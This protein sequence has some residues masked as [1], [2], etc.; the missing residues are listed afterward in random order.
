[1][2]IKL[3]PATPP[4]HVA[5]AAAR[6][7]YFPDGIVTPE[8]TAN[9]P[10]KDDLL[11]SVFNAGHHTT[12]QHTHVTLLIEG[13]S[14]HLIWR[15]LH[16]HSF[17]NSEQ[18]SQR[19]AR[20]RRENVYIPETGDKAPWE[21]FYQ[22][23]FGEYEIL[24]AL[25]VPK[26]EALLP[27][28]LKKQAVKKAQEFARYI[29]PVG[30][31]AYLYHTVN[32]I[33]LLRYI[34]AAPA[35]PEAATEG[36]LF[37]SLLEKALLELDPSLAPL[38]EEAKASP[39]SFPKI[40]IDTITSAHQIKPGEDVRIFDVV[41]GLETGTP[42]NYASVLRPSQL[43]FDTSI[44]GGFSSYLK[45]SLSADAQNQRHRRSP[46]IRPA[47]ESI[48][49]PAFYTPAL[50]EGEALQRYETIIA[51]SYRF[52]ETQR[53]KIGFGEAVYALPNAH[54]IQIV[55]RNDFA[56]FHHKAQMRLCYNAQEEIFHLTY[57][58]VEQ[59]RQ[60]Q[61][62]GSEQLLPPCTLRQ[63]QGIYPICPEGPRFC[64]IKVWKL[65][66][67]QYRRII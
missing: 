58:Q 11:Q 7:C 17:Y 2:R 55:E 62:R 25:L 66:F 56:S 9:W 46:A 13:M 8:A 30:L 34:A 49:A 22:E 19:Y 4:S 37:A 24:I 28:F 63:Q 42:E 59:L 15:L 35:L 1:M 50:L 20:M 12:L 65:P 40:A 38:I 31:T 5:V 14:R 41:G 54:L 47:L 44:L 18:V 53:D 26:I 32:V 67:D 3:L 29:L 6:T 10:R 60:Q 64:G 36:R 43:F 23:I 52:F 16:S 39:A 21:A 57:R 45:L 27:K 61:V 51:K 48:Y 33:T